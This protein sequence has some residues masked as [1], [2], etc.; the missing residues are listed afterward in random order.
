VYKGKFKLIFISEAYKTV[1][2]LNLLNWTIDISFQRRK[3]VVL[4]Q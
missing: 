2:I 3:S 4:I 1:F